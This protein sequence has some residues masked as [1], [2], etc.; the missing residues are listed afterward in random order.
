VSNGAPRVYGGPQGPRSVGSGSPPPPPPAEGLPP[1]RP[2]AAPIADARETEPFHGPLR[3]DRGPKQTPERMNHRPHTQKMLGEGREGGAG[4]VEPRKRRLG[5]MLLIQD[6]PHFNT[7]GTPAASN[8]IIGVITHCPGVVGTQKKPFLVCTPPP[9][10]KG[11]QLRQCSR[12]AAVFSYTHKRGYLLRLEPSLN[13]RVPDSFGSLGG[14]RGLN[15]WRL[16]PGR[17]NPNPSCNALAE[18][19]AGGAPTAS[20]PGVP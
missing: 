6:L 20:D 10:E 17:A 3:F 5:K 2:S 11:D 19:A 18:D 14:D 4:A 12:A 16:M 1:R 8:G 15:V 13:R 9:P 7:S